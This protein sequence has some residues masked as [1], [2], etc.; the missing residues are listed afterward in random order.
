MFSSIFNI[1]MTAQKSTN[2]D[3]FI[4]KMHTAVTAV[5]MQ[6]NKTVSSEVKDN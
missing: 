1:K 4:F 5:T 2:L 6:S 3:K